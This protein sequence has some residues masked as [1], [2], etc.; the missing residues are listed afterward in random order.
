MALAEIENKLAGVWV[1]DRNENL[2]E[3]MKEIGVNLCYMARLASSTMTISIEDGQ[4][5]IN[6][7]GPKDSDHKFHLDQEVESSDPQDN[8]MK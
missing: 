1:L 3:Y 2:D 7:K 6:T 4:V 5:R 8:P